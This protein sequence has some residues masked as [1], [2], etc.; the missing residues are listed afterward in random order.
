MWWDGC[1]GFNGLFHLRTYK[2]WD[3]IGVI[4]NPLILTFDPKVLTS[5]G[6]PSSELFGDLAVSSSGVKTF[7]I[8]R[9]WSQMR[10]QVCF[11]NKSPTKTP[12][13]IGYNQEHKGFFGGER[14]I[15]KPNIDF[16]IYDIGGTIMVG[17]HFHVFFHEKLWSDLEPRIL[18]IARLLS[19]TGWIHHHKKQPSKSNIHE[20]VPSSQEPGREKK[21]KTVC[22]QRKVNWYERFWGKI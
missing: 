7:S 12:V 21:N 10:H 8:S 9:I 6:H 17:W 19:P 22:S 15:L 13:V 14:W 1:L 16:Q 11:W 20:G 3:L 2:L 18:K 4:S 5:S